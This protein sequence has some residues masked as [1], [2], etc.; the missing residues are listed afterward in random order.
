M[1]SQITPSLKWEGGRSGSRPLRARPETVDAAPADRVCNKDSDRDRVYGEI[2]ARRLRFRDMGICDRPTAPRSPWQN[3]PAK[4]LIGSLRREC[5][6]HIVVFGER[7][8]RHVLLLF[9]DYCDRARP[10]LS[11]NKDAPVSRAVQAVGC[12]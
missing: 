8:L 11:S 6:D 3:G 4:R 9:I 5:L 7:H 10:H 2:F 1:F 12:L